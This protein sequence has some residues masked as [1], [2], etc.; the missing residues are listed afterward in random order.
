MGTAQR[1][2]HTYDSSS[3]SVSSSTVDLPKD[4]MDNKKAGGDD[5]SAVPLVGGFAMS[6]YAAAALLPPP[7]PPPAAPPADADGLGALHTEHWDAVGVF[8]AVHRGHAHGGGAPFDTPH[9]TH[10]DAPA[11]LATGG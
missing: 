5:G 9:M 6:P 11:A 7:P 10:S 4:V 3:V 8:V 1:H 2:G